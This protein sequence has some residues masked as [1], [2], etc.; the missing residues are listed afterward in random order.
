METFIGRLTSNA[1]INTLNDERQVVNFSIVINNTYRAKN[2]EEQKKATTYINCAFWLSTKVAEHLI[3]GSIV[4]ISGRLFVRAY[5]S[6]NEPKASLNC[7]VNH[8]KIHYFQTALNSPA[9][10]AAMAAPA[11]ADDNLPF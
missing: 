3:K 11:E 9:P 8:I 6:G 5:L 7:H 2:N 1:Q 4:E 10:V